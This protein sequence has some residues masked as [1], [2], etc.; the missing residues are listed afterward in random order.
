MLVS[1][2]IIE[3]PFMSSHHIRS[4]TKGTSWK[5]TCKNEINYS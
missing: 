3:Y 5:H 1:L 2:N 4:Q